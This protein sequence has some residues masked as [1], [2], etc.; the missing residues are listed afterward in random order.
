MKKIGNLLQS[1]N[2]RS[3]KYGS[4]SV[5]LIV[6]VIAIAVVL[7]LMVDTVQKKNLIKTK[8]DLTSNH[9][10]SIGD[11]SKEILKSLN[12]DVEIYGLVDIG[13][14]NSNDSLKQIKE[15]LSQYEK[16]P[17]IK[18]TYL[19]P[20]KT[21][22]LVKKIDPSGL[23]DLKK[24]DF[25]VKSG[26][27]VRKLLADEIIYNDYDQ[28][29]GQSRGSYFTGEQGF[30]GAIKYVTSEKTPVV[31]FTSGHGEGKPES[32]YKNL[33]TQL[34]ANNYEVKSLNLLTTEKMP[35]DAEILMVAS[36]KSDLSVE[37]EAKISNFLKNGGKAVFAFDSQESDVKYT[38]FEDL[39]K[40]FNVGLNYDKVKENDNQRHFPN[41][42]YA[43][44]LDVPKSTV[45][46]LDGL[47]VVLGNS[48][49]INMLKNQKDY[50]T[51]T[52][53]MKTSDKAVGEQIDKSRGKDNK[54]PLDL[55]VAVE[56]K[57]GAKPSKVLVMGNGLFVSDS[58][59]NQY[60]QYYQNGYNFFA[61]SL[62]WMMDKKD[63]V[64]IEP[65]SLDTTQMKIDSA[66]QAAVIA[67]LV[68][69]LFPLLILGSGLFVWM[70][71]KHL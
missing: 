56:N 36:P 23:K 15:V 62:N 69:I 35:D 21:P 42:P 37:E 9:L 43:I 46:P 54:G 51:V 61:V 44:V 16:Y 47:Q 19:D 50:I 53:L 10:Y 20:D 13:T 34:E 68:V 5:V 7:N 33:K 71:R 60:K 39:L 8:F 12:K 31:Y 48:R 58:A 27:K 66:A 28:S 70:R 11:K 30:T 55:A 29:T 17:H 57:G 25:V 14:I 1:I 6:A 45:I 64:L 59:V 24:G 32:D 67:I 4:I 38:Q 2:R 3:L 41:D 65:K 18:V 40:D 22:G 63:E 52:S 49:S 26:N